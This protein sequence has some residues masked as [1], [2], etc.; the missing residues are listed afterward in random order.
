MRDKNT[1]PA[2]EVKN[3]PYKP[4]SEQ[5]RL[6]VRFLVH[7]QLNPSAAAR[8]AGYSPNPRTAPDLLANPAV[9]HAIDVAREEYL[10][11]S[12][13]T[14]KKVID[15]FLEA[16]DIA[17]TQAEPSSM[18]AGWREIG[19]VCGLYE[20]TKARLDV[21]V[22]GRVVLQRLEAMTDDELLKLIQEHATPIEGVFTSDST[23]SESD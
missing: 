18:I 21:A 10:V 2:I 15:G 13:M 20:P 19:R 5:Q 22:H 4:L 12:Q 1:F 6:F 14:R 16:I 23:P 8:A 17:R 9:R 7:E 3:S 11:A